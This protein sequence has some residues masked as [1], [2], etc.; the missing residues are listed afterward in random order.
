MT[1]GKTY[2]S[3]CWLEEDAFKSWLSKA[4]NKKQARRRLYEKDFEL[5]NMGKK[6]L[7][8]H[9]ASK[10]HSERVIKIKTFFKPAN[11]LKMTMVVAQILLHM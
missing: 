1:Q 6:A 7:L 4:A 2:F 5:S 8:S 3:D 11:Q 9:T 10:K